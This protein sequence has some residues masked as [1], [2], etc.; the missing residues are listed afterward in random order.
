MFYY[1]WINR[2]EKLLKVLKIFLIFYTL[3]DQTCREDYR[4]ENCLWLNIHIKRLRPAIVVKNFNGKPAVDFGSA[5]IGEVEKRTLLVENISENEVVMK[6]S[7]LDP[8]GPFQFRFK[9][10]V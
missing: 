5:P 4:V 7:L 3:V 2:F 6:S 8:H 9:M 1:C 10:I